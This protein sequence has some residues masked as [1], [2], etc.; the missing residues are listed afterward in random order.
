[1]ANNLTSNTQATLSKK[2]LERFESTR[3]ISKTVNTQFLADAIN[4]NTGDTV[5]V[6]RPGRFK[7]TRTANGDI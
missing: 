3:T 4:S 2:I 1:M 7:S 5:Y 6:K